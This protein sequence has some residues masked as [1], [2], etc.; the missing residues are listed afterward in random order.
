ME[1]VGCNLK[2]W[3]EIVNCPLHFHK[4]LHNI[5]EVKWNSLSCVQLFVTSRTVAS[6]SPLSMR[7]SRQEYWSGLSFLSSGCLPDPG[8][9]PGAPALQA[10]SLPSE[11]L[12]KPQITSLPRDRGLLHCRQ[13][14]YRLNS[15]PSDS[16]PPGKSIILGVV[17]LENNSLECLKF[18]GKLKTFITTYWFPSCLMTLKNHIFNLIL[19]ELL[20]IILLAWWYI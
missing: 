3:L 20:N 9:K 10:D 6:Q 17:L 14:L 2:T 8:F 12:T 5:F 16:L 19:I 4:M 18:P 7:F 13:I 1:K 15:L 11:P